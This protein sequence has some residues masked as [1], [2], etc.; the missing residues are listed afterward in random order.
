MSFFLFRIDFCSRT[1]RHAKPAHTVGQFIPEYARTYTYVCMYNIYIVNERG[2]RVPQFDD[3]WPATER[4]SLC[5][6]GHKRSRPARSQSFSAELSRALFPIFRPIFPYDFRISAAEVRAGTPPSPS[7]QIAVRFFPLAKQ[8]SRLSVGWR[9]TGSGPDP[10]LWGISGVRL[11]GGYA[12]LVAMLTLSEVVVVGGTRISGGA[13]LGWFSCVVHCQKVSEPTPPPLSVLSLVFFKSGLTCGVWKV[14]FEDVPFFRLDFVFGSRLFA[15]RRNS[16]D[17]F[18]NMLIFWSGFEV[19]LVGD[20]FERFLFSM[21]WLYVQY[22][23]YIKME[24]KIIEVTVTYLVSRYHILCRCIYKSL[25]FIIK[26][27]VFLLLIIKY[28]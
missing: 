2:A 16:C 10:M 18:Y 11:F 21:V 23:I 26:D 28:N 17:T 5:V 27:Y 20:S 7:R 19:L 6:A 14:Y 4:R 15:K 8:F 3:S 22:F 9:L 12:N 13:K 1:E 25:Y 24:I